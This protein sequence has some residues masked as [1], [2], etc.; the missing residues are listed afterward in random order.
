MN[1]L[2]RLRPRLFQKTGGASTRAFALLCFAFGSSAFSFAAPQFKLALPGYKYQFPRDHA[3]HP[4]FATEWWYYTGHLRAKNG[5]KFGYQLTFF[6]QAL[7]PQIAPRKSGWATR[8]V[9]FAHFAL[10]D[11]TKNR[12]FFS[13]RT[14]RAAAGLAKAETNI[15]RVFLGHWAMQINPNS[16]ILRAASRDDNSPNDASTRE[17]KNAAFFAIN[18]TQT[19]R[20]NPVIH[21][22]NG[23]SQKS[24]GRGRASHY[25]SFTR[26]QTRGAVQIDNETFQVAGESWF[27]HEFGSN[28][29]ARNQV[30]WDWFSL[31]LSDGRELMLYQLRNRGGGMDA[32]SSGTLVE[33][34]GRATHLRVGDFSIRPLATWKSAASGATYPSRWRILVPRAKIDLEVVPSIANQELRTQRSSRI[35]YWEGSARVLARENREAGRG[36]VELT[37][38]DK[39]FEGS[40]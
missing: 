12:F 27:D 6:R 19:P 5:R 38:Y 3:S 21:G 23:V 10:T 30:G 22:E 11:E 1:L 4:P 31:Q 25:V 37:G 17:E 24:A 29:L 14:S 8:D 16:H 20:K 15:P 9:I 35:A 34:S 2:F 33:K 13:D 40:F 39:P 7:S 36:Y 26:L 18:L 28:Q 32:F